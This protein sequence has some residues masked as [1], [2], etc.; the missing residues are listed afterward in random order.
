VI[1]PG[2]DI[3][4]RLEALAS[5]GGY[6]SRDEAVAEL[7]ALCVA[8]GATLEHDAP[9]R[10]RERIEEWVKRLL[11]AA[12]SVAASFDARDFSVSVGWPSGVSVSFT[13]SRE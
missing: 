9:E 1:T 5:F 13:W 3:S 12:R 6:Q 4:D 2:D 11:N 7:A 10:R 8:M